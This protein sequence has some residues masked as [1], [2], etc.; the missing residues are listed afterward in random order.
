MNPVQEKDDGKLA[1]LRE[2]LLKD[3]EL[4]RQAVEEDV[5]SLKE[6]ILNR[7]NFGNHLAP[8][9][10]DNVEYLQQNYPNLFGRYLGEAI[11]L[12]IR[13]SQGEIIDA[14]YPIIG[15]LISKYLREEFRR[16][17]EQIDQRLSD[18]FSWKN[19]R[20]RAKALFTG[21]SY[22]EM[23][24]KETNQISVEQ[25]FVIDKNSG[26]LLGHASFKPITSPDMVAGMLKGVQDFVEHALETQKQEL[27]TLEYD[28]NTILLYHFETITFAVVIE[29]EPDANFKQ[30]MRD[31]LFSFIEQHPVHA[32][33]SVTQ[34]DQDAL[35]QKLQLHFNGFDQN[36]Q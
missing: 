22:Q 32:S 4:A 9:L 25:L 23:L 29:G 36:D 28:R 35:A 13:N 7:E 6:I 18:P 1:Q 14:L 10:A 26:L 15:K 5:N 31:Q 11:K 17:S 27:E 30:D 19:I 24:I 2:L 3:E 16:I 33:N 12:Q 20:L 34:A 8:H 21:T